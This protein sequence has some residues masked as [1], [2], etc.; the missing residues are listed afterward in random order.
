MAADPEK[1][2]RISTYD[3]GYFEPNGEL[4]R[5]NHQ[6]LLVG[7]YGSPLSQE[8]KKH[9]GDITKTYPQYQLLLRGGACYLSLNHPVIF[10]RSSLD[11]NPSLVVMHI[12]P[13]SLG[14]IVGNGMDGKD[15]ISG[16]SRNHFRLTRI[17]G[18]ILIEYLSG[19]TKTSIYDREGKKRLG[20]APAKGEI[21]SKANLG[22]GEFILIDAERR[23]IGFRVCLD[24]K[25]DELYLVKFNLEKIDE[26]PTLAR[27][28]R[29]REERASDMT[30]S[31]TVE[32]STPR[33]SNIY[34]RL[35]DEVA[36][37]RE[38]LGMGTEKIISRGMLVLVIARRCK[39]IAGQGD[40]L[41][42]TRQA[43]KFAEITAQEL[44]MKGEKQRVEDAAELNRI[45]NFLQGER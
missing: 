20:F 32:P 38:S 5:V 7:S 37:S 21:T 18:Q 10:G 6:P 14:N 43:R 8:L 3:D 13:D 19:T 42:V 35:I 44:L 25:D 40:A 29:E 31:F 41:E 30:T 16:V 11:R 28:I 4:W 33:P 45:L 39:I 24:P 34:E 12:D 23:F 27:K 22:I 17:P 1:D 15:S 36:E 9:W 26:L 2:F